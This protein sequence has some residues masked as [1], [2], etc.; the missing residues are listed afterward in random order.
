MVALTSQQDCH[1]P[2]QQHRCHHVHDYTHTAATTTIIIVTTLR[3]DA[4]TKTK[5]AVQ[6]SVSWSPRS[7]TLVLVSNLV[8]LRNFETCH[9]AVQPRGQGACN[10][11]T[12]IAH[13]LPTPRHTPDT[14][15]GNLESLLQHCKRLPAGNRRAP[16][17]TTTLLILA[18]AEASKAAEPRTC[19]SRSGCAPQS[20]K[21]RHPH[22]AASSAETS[23]APAA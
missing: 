17:T 5:M 13:T 10:K 23:W 6:N 7:S 12:I 2:R 19:P 14:T 21:V 20:P 8:H 4:T 3:P 9:S 1:Q 22:P 16:A 15:S 11:K 18:P